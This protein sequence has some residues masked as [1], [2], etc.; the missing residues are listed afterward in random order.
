VTLIDCDS[1]ATNYRNELYRFGGN[2]VTETTIVRTGGASDGTT[3]VSWKII[4]DA[5]ARWIAPFESLPI[6]VWSDT[7]GAKTVSIYGYWNNASVPNNDDIWIEFEGLTDAGSPLSSIATSGKT[8]FLA[9]NAPIPSDASTWGGG[10]TT[11]KFK[12]SAAITAAMKGPISVTVKAAKASSTFYIDPKIKINGV[13]IDRS[14]M[15]SPG[16]YVN[17]LGGAGG[18][19]DLTRF[20]RRRRGRF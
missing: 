5:N 19:L 4:T 17:E 15:L 13:A 9:A 7:V 18:A 20:M 10:V 14:E 2:Q 11:S 6:T 8:S 16:V 1:G 12:M 3:P